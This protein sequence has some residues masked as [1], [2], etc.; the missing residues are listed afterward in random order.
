MDA[1]FYEE[2]FRS[3]CWEKKTSKYLFVEALYLD[4]A[5]LKQSESGGAD[6]WGNKQHDFY[7]HAEDEGPKVT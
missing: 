2:L 6:G 7:M 5:D 3:K 1:I 4:L